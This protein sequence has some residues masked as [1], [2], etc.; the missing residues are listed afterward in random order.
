MIVAVAAG[1]QPRFTLDPTRGASTITAYIVA[2]SQGDLPHG[3]IGYRAIF[4]AGLMLFVMTL[5]FNLAGTW[6]RRRFREAY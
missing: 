1:G 5:L 4:A 6:L 3:S 2:V